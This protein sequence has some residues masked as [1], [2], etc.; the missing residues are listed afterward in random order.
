[1]RSKNHPPT[2]AQKVYWDEL[3]STGCVVAG[4]NAPAEIDHVFGASAKHRKLHI[5]QWAVIPLCY[6][7]HRG[8][9]GRTAKEYLFR[10]DWFPEMEFYEMRRE[11]LRKAHE[12][13]EQYHGKRVPIPLDVLE[14]MYQYRK[15][16]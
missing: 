2:A 8:A 6:E 14:A 3:T 15:G 7:L 16:T 10:D 12:N 11:L 5:G 13:Y 1:M 4:R 9:R